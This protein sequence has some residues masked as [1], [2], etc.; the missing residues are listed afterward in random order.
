MTGGALALCG[1]LTCG[2]ATA[3]AQNGYMACFDESTYTLRPLWT[4]CVA[5][6]AAISCL[7]D[8]ICSGNPAVAVWYV[9][10]QT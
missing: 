7:E 6:D 5:Q 3:L 1:S 4:S 10:S 9:I 2:Y 8:P